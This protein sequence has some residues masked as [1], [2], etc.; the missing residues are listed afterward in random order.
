MGK[1]TGFME[2]ARVHP[3]KREKQERLGDYRE[4][5]L[6]L[7]PEEAKRQA[8][9]C[10]DC[11]VP[12]C[13]QGCPLG[14]LI[15]DFNEAVYRG[16]WREAYD[17]LTRTNGFPEMTGRLC[18]APCEAACVLAIDRD[19]VTIEQMEKEIA[20]RAFTEGW[21]KPRP[22]PR[23][24]GRTVGVVGSGPAGLAA[25]AQL[26]AAGHSVTVYERDPKAGGLLRYGIPDF[27][28]EKSVV[29]RRLALMEAEGVVFRTGVDVGGS[30]SFRELRGRH[31][32]LLLAMGARRARE[33]EV[34]GRELSGV[35][36]AMEYLEHQNRLVDGHGEQQERLNAAGKRVVILGGGDTGSDCLGTALR[37]GAK[38]VQ[39]IELFPSPPSVRAL[40]NPWPR[41][42]VVFRTS[43]SQEEGGERGFAM[44]T[45]RLVGTDGKL[46]ALHA[47][48]VEV[49][50]AVGGGPR[51]V[52]VP[53]SEPTLEVDLLI[54]AMGF[55]GPETTGLV[56]DLGVALSPRGTVQVDKRFATSADGVYSAGDASR[57]AS[58]IVWAL[59]D[60]REAAK[61]IDAYLSGGVSVLPT[62]GADSPF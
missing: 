8:G 55:T 51:L 45:K 38:S 34:P 58:L 22:P 20:E 33:L 56:D 7:A 36:Q 4:F 23:R 10:M 11:G 37:Q 42:P 12:F 1:P 30:V 14:N 26:N 16:R 57:G 60:G 32:A 50:R 21:V 46:E 27:K 5:A 29:D 2:W 35:V 6:P 24:T 61:S 28:L 3:H 62:R 47:V 53:D 48:K 15:P 59:S 13:H 54:L 43:S 18:P 31:D 41:W 9:R 17:I 44:Q 40:D 19:A 25:A 49:Q 52:E 39:Q